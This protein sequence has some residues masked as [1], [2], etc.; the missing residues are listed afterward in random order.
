MSHPPALISRR[1]LLQHSALAILGMP[2]LGSAAGCVTQTADSKTN[3]EITIGYVPIACTTPLILAHAQGLFQARGL[4]I[5]LKKYGGWADLWSAYSTGELDIA[6]MLSPMP[7]AINAGT[8]RGKR[9]TLLAFTQNT[10][11]QA[12]T[13]ATKHVNAVQSA[14]DFRGKVIGIPFEYSVH[15]LLFRDFLASEGIDPVSDIELRLLR[16]ADMIAQLQVGGIDGFVGPEPFNQRAVASGAG[17]I[18]KLT[19]ELWSGHPCCSIAMS[20][21][22]ASIHPDQAKLLTEALGEAAAFANNPANK[23][24]VAK[25]LAEEKYLNQPEK[26]FLP[27]LSGEYQNWHGETVADQQRISFGDATDPT[28]IT[29][30]ATQIARWKLGG[31]SIVMEDSTLIR[32]AD[33]VLPEGIAAGGE[34]ATINGKEFNPNIPTAGY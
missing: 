31:T 22:W 12:I 13:L 34:T 5:K 28:A 19:K 30:M 9:P 15:A 14:Q 27:S 26:F 32:L 16:P 17:R 29:W 6:H 4:T 11:G 20:K 21:D 10:N 24:T 7:I 1:N 23:E 8:T 2:L 33:S 25:I 3:A 18:F